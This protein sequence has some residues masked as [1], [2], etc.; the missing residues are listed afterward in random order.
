MSTK[1]KKKE[2]CLHIIQLELKAIRLALDWRLRAGQKKSRLVHLVDSQVAFA[3]V[4]K[5]RTSSFRLLPE[6][7]RIAAW[8]IAGGLY[9]TY[10]YVRSKWNPSDVPN[11]PK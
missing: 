7:R 6:A 11:R 10:G 4:C 1:V 3:V 5:G 9:P 2:R 8:C